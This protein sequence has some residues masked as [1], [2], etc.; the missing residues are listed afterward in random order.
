MKHKNINFVLYKLLYE[1][2]YSYEWIVELLA[3]FSSA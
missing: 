3:I 2:I 1:N